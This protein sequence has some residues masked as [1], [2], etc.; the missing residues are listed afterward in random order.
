MAPSAEHWARIRD[1]FESA[2]PMS[3]HLRP[4]HLAATCGDDSQLREEVERLLA[5]HEQ[6][7]RFLGTH[8][9][10]TTIET[11]R[12]PLDGCQVGPYQVIREIGRG[13]MGSVYLAERADGAFE[14]RVAIKFVGGCENAALL[15]RFYDE[16]RILAAFEHPNI[17]RLLDGGTTAD[18]MPYFVMEY[19]DG[20]GIYEFCES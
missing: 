1:V 3:A 13:G 18:G 16:R 19:V 7:S 17:A 20:A 11:I 5:S 10:L 8:S 15:R 2:V 9:A 14:Q 4:A 6:A 12:T